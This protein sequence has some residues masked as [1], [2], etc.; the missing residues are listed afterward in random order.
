MCP[1]SGQCT[2]V[3][4]SR[5]GCNRHVE[6]RSTCG[7]HRPSRNIVPTVPV[8]AAKAQSSEQRPFGPGGS[9]FGESCGHKATRAEGK[10]R[11]GAQGE[12]S[13]VRFGL[14]VRFGSNDSGTPTSAA[15]L[16]APSQSPSP[17]SSRR[18]F[19]LSTL[20]QRNLHQF[21]KP[22]FKRLTE[23]LPRT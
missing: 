16:F 19:R 6:S 3:T 1:E 5:A 8:W 18:D 21:A 11:T 10:G 17:P 2:T 13:E 7:R 15:R 23:A 4:R 9:C 12:R 22:I 14:T 20:L